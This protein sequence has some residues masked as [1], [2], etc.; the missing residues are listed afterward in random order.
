[1]KGKRL[2]LALTFLGG[3]EE[4]CSAHQ[5]QSQGI[6]VSLYEGDES[7]ASRPGLP[8]E[9]SNVIYTKHK[10]VAKKQPAAK[11]SQSSKSSWFNRMVRRFFQRNN[12]Q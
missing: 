3:M 8:V 12:S 5:P 9:P 1:M 7:N 4:S 11:A 2:V 6:F 10:A